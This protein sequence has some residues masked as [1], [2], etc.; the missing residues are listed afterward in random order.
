MVYSKLTQ[1]YHSKP[2]QINN[3]IVNIFVEY[4]GNLS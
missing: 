3:K 2:W 4:Y 1:G